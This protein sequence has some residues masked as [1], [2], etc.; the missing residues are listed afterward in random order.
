VA[1]TRRR[2][3]RCHIASVQEKRRASY[4]RNEMAFATV[5]DRTLFSC[6]LGFAKPD[7]AFYLNVQTVL[8]KQPGQLLL[9]DDSLACIE[10]AQAVGWH[11]FHYSGP[12]DQSRLAG[13]LAEL[14]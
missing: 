7:A 13:A 6:E 10:A 14:P 5:F 12:A 1:A 3:I 11:T 9:V 8:G 4:L 2:G